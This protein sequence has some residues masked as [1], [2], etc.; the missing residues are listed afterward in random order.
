MNATE[1][2]IADS[3]SKHAADAPSD[4]HLLSTIHHRLRRRRT[5]RTIGAAVLA[6][7][8]VA[9]AITAS[10]SLTG[11]LRTD[12]Q[13]A[14]PGTPASGWHWE[15][16][17]TAQVQVPDSWTQYISGPAPCTT[18]GNTALPTIGRFNDWL[19][20]SA[21]T[22]EDAVLPLGRRSPYL[23]FNDVQAPGI[24]QYDAGWTE[25]TRLVAGT[26]ISV[27]TKD[28]ALRRRIL[29]SARP[30]TGTDYY[31]CPPTDVGPEGTGL[32]AKDPITSASICEYWQGSLISASQLAAKSAA[33]FAQRVNASP[34]GSQRARFEGCRQPD[35]RTYVVTLHGREKSYPV[36]LIAD[37]CTVDHSFPTDDGSTVRRADATTLDLIKQGVHHPNQPSDLFDPA[38]PLT[39][40]PR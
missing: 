4:E 37:Y 2:L 3:L 23:W 33:A 17:K 14:R 30:I 26:K 24:K 19:G 31:G 21:Y 36:R 39:P 11:E 16:Y 15:S 1:D 40:S 25:E 20:K 12:P 7:T 27:L 6:C 18:F 13:V 5:G 22:C 38:G 28:D 8:A 10:H 9:T 32:N 29:D 34:E 35:Q